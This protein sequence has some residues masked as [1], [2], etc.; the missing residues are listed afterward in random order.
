MQTFFFSAET[1]LFLYV[2]WQIVRIL[3]SVISISVHLILKNIIRAIFLLT[4]YC[5]HKHLRSWS[6]F[7]DKTSPVWR[8]LSNQLNFIVFPVCIFFLLI[9]RG[10]CSEQN[11]TLSN[12]IFK[13]GLLSAMLQRSSLTR[14][15]LV[16]FSEVRNLQR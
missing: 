13:S 8:A 7:P 2:I 10:I 3:V 5:S 14:S 15:F 12:A 6:H 1:L 9:F 16:V 11:L 4:S